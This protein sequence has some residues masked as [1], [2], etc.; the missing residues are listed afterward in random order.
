MSLPAFVELANAGKWREAFAAGEKILDGAPTLVDIRTLGF[1]WSG[2]PPGPEACAALLRE[3]RGKNGA[4]AW[5]YLVG[6][7]A[8][9]EEKREAANRLRSLPDR[10]YGWMGYW[11]SRAFFHAEGY[12]RSERELRRALKGKVVN[13][14]AY[15]T[16]AEVLVCRGRPAE[17]LSQFE[18]A[19]RAAIATERPAVRAWRGTIKLWL[20][21]YR[22]G[23]ADLD[24][25]CREGA[26]H[27]FCWRGAAALL[28]GRPKDALRDLDDAL[29]LRADD[30]EARV[31][32]AEAWLALG[33]PRKAL[34]ALPPAS[35]GFWDRVGRARAQLALGRAAEAKDEVDQ[36]DRMVV[37]RLLPKAGLARVETPADRLRL[38][39]AAARLARGFRRDAYCQD[40][41]LS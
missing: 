37:D 15:G 14:W 10:R 35:R 18:P 9:P 11:I 41:W 32:K 12:E 1:P 29:R 36:L 7:R 22:S 2:P 8:Q 31:W 40:A 17:A 5:F 33:Q 16:L 34:A 20:G 39:E 30:E 28:L 13:W 4:W 25:A 23:H 21:R 6:A 24:R 38:L 3:T 27:A 19:L 26:E